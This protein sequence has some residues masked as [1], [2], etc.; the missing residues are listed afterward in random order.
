MPLI[1]VRALDLPVQIQ[2]DPPELVAGV[3]GILPPGAQPCAPDVTHPT[4]SVTCT[5]PD[6][7]EVA[8]DAMALVSGVEQSV[9]VAVLDARIRWY[10]STCCTTHVLVHAGAVAWRGLGIVMPG[11]S[12]SG[13]STLVTA[14][15][16]AGATYYSD[17]LAILTRDGQLLP[18]PRAITARRQG[19]R[20]TV[21]LKPADLGAVVGRTPVPIG[22]IA[23]TQYEP[24]SVWMPSEVAPAEG[25]LGLLINTAAAREDPE[26]VLPVLARASHDAH[27]LAGQRGDSATVAHSLLAYL[28]NRSDAS[29]SVA[30]LSDQSGC[31]ASLR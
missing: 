16:E 26:R 15:L 4:F 7:Y 17:E 6:R 22:L 11:T 24:D 5:A 14:L 27:V 18:Y 12:R 30:A 31:S 1:C 23:L 19:I 3:L 10:L 21:R 13:K 28:G 8:L 9:A 2:I 20:G 25:M 29:S